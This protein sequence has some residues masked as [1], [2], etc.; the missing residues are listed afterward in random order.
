MTLPRE[1]R[2]VAPATGEVFGA[3]SSELEELRA[4]DLYRAPRVFEG[5]AD[6]VVVKDGRELLCFASNNYLGLTADE[7]V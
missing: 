1:I 5:Q 2:G 6:R 4:A 7:A 3:L